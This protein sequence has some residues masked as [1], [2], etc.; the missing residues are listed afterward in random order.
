MLWKTQGEKNL[1]SLERR[2]HEAKAINLGQ[3][4][5]PIPPWEKYKSGKW[6][7]TK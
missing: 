1:L 3:E 7:H 4:F 5:L 2:N 6:N